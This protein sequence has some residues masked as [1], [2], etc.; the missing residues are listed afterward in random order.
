MYRYFKAFSITQYAEYV[1]DGNLNDYLMKVL[2][3]L[4]RL[5][6]TLSYHN[7]KI[8]VKFNGCCLKQPKISYTHGTIVNI[9]IVYELGASSSHS[10]DLTLKNS[11]FGTVRLT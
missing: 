10:D 11:L 7:T 8:R 3:R 5:I 2:R 4:L 9:Y 6:I 1:S